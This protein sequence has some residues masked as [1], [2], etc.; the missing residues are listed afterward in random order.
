MQYSES[1]KL[2]ER[3]L[4]PSNRVMIAD[5]AASTDFQAEDL[6]NCHMLR[7]VSKS[8]RYENVDF[9]YTIFEHCYFRK[10]KFIDCDFTGCKFIACN[11]DGASF[12]GCKFDYS[13]FDRVI[14]DPSILENSCPGAENIRLRFARSL[15]VNFQQMGDAAGA[16]RAVR[17][18]INAT[19]EFYF[20][21]WHSSESYY[22][23]KYKGVD[24][25]W[26]FIKWLSFRALDAAWGHGEN[27]WKLIRLSLIL[28]T[29]VVLTDYY[30]S[31]GD[32]DI[33]VSLAEMPQI[34]LGVR[35]PEHMNQTMV[36][37]FIF[38]RY[39]IFALFITIFVRR[40]AR[41]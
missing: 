16:N 13:N 19:N 36:S 3:H 25:L 1:T 11:F 22:R 7:F 33:F 34:L 18:E 31:P 38:A 39:I 21:S 6:S 32:T 41:R 23:R 30:S 12:D 37:F 4:P 29:A 10:S 9:K 17:T 24:R 40:F 27:L 28:C 8:R 15:R 5:K 14:I 35:Y 26:M 20:K 2:K